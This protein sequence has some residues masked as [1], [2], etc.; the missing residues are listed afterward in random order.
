MPLALKYSQD[1]FDKKTYGVNAGVAVD[2]SLRLS[3]EYSRSE[4]V[5]DA[6]SL[7]L[8]KKVSENTSMVLSVGKSD[9]EGANV[10][11]QFQSKF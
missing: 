11:Y 9:K 5:G 10:M 2:K 1:A 6:I 4:S 8:Q 3:T 7:N